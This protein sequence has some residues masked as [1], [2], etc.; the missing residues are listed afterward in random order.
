MQGWKWIF[1]FLNKLLEREKKVVHAWYIIIWVVENE[2][3]FQKIL[4]KSHF[5]ICRYLQKRWSFWCDDQHYKNRETPHHTKC[6]WGTLFTLIWSLFK[7]HYG[8][9]SFH[10]PQGSNSHWV[11]IIAN[12]LTPKGDSLVTS[13]YNIHTLF[14]KGW[15][16]YSILS[17]RS[18]YLDLTLNSLSQFTRKCVEAR[19]EN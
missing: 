7:L 2:T 1:S 14:L 17:G 8:A 3:S 5:G 11:I 4:T 16:E 15:W 9:H 6:N 13:P 12:P 18:C 19:R 10:C